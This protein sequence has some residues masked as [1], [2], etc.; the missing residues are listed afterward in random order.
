MMTPIIAKTTEEM[1]KLVPKALREAS[2]GLGGSKTQT[3]RRVVIPAASGGIITGIMLAVARVAGET[4]PLLFTVLGSDLPIFSVDSKFPF[5]HADLNHAFPSLTV[6][7]F[8]YAGS[9]EPDWNRQAWAGMLIL[10]VLV[11]VLNILVRVASNRKKYRP[12]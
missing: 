5:F 4:A 1:L 9:A 7:I 2:I 8:K 11:L 10:I 6:Q 3:L 12:A